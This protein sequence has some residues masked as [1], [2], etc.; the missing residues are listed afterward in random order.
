MDLEIYDV[1]QREA[2]DLEWT[3]TDDDGNV[4][5]V[6]SAECSLYCKESKGDASYKFS[7]ST[8]DFDLSDGANGVILVTIYRADLDFSGEVYCELKVVISSGNA[9]KHQFKLYVESEVE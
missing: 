9:P 7:K 8:S 4:V 1:I 5:D 6:S 3:I 2:F